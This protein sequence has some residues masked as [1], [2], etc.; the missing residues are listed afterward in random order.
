RIHPPR[1]DRPQARPAR[2]HRDREAVGT[3]PRV[4][5]SQG[6]GGRAAARRARAAGL[7]HTLK[8]QH[9]HMGSQI[10]NVRDIANGMREASRYFVELSR[11]GVP[12]EIVDV[13]GGL[14]V[15]YEGSR[16]RSHNSINYSIEQYAATI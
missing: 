14:G 1:A 3:R 10:S 15:D 13:G 6:A 8:L 9:F 11:M 16:S 7:K 4:R 2:A 12:L 5:R